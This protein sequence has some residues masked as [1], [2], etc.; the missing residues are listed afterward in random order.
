MWL[1]GLLKTL[2][3]AFLGKGWSGDAYGVVTLGTA[4]CARRTHWHWRSFESARRSSKSCCFAMAACASTKSAVPR[5]VAS[6]TKPLCSSGRSARQSVGEVAAKSVGAVP[7]P[8]H[9][10]FSS[11]W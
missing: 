10:A 1:L 6:S 3:P 5:G 9:Q 11:P 4:D 2:K 8:L 7:L